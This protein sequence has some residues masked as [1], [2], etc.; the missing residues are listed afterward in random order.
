[1]TTSHPAS[2]P[3]TMEAPLITYSRPSVSET[4]R[5]PVPAV[6]SRALPDEGLAIA[7]SIAGSTAATY[8]VL[9]LRRSSTNR[10]S[11]WPTWTLSPWSSGVG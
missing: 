3:N 7:A 1:M 4:T 10:S 6:A 8:C 5:P 2:R 9:P 11:C